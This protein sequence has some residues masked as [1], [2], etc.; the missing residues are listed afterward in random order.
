MDALRFSH[1][2]QMLL[3][4][5]RWPSACAEYCGAAVPSPD[6]RWLFQG[7][8]VCMAIHE[9]PDF[10][11]SNIVVTHTVTPHAKDEDGPQAG[12]VLGRAWRGVGGISVGRRAYA[13]CNHGDMGEDFM[14]IW[15]LHMHVQSY[16]V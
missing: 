6:G 10:Y 14:C 13:H 7:P 5:T 3:V 4:H 9:S 12:L 8:R 15:A 11:V 2:A 1:A 16:A